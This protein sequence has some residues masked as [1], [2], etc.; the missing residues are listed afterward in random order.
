MCLHRVGVAFHRI[1]HLSRLQAPFL[2]RL[3]VRAGKDGSL[4]LANDHAIHRKDICIYT[5][6]KN[7]QISLYVCTYLYMHAYIYT[8]IYIT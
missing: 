2:H 7:I 5:Y 4:L 1:Q 8:Y 6:T 3:V